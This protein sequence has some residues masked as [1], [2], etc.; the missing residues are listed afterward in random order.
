V[1]DGRSTIRELVDLVNQ[2]P[3]RSDGHSTVLSF[4]KL[5]AI[6][7]EVLAEQGMTPDSVPAAGQ[8]I[9]IRRNG[10]LST[11]GT[12]TDITD[13]V[14]PE[15]AAQAIDAARVIGLDIAG[16]DIVARDIS[17]PMDGQRGAVVEVNAGPGLRMHIEPTEGKPRPVGDAIV[18]LVYPVGE[19]GRIPLAGVTGTIGRTCAIKL[20]AQIL[21]ID[22]TPVGWTCET[23]IHLGDRALQHPAVRESDYARSLLL[24]PAVET[25]VCGASTSSIVREGLGYDRASVGIVTDLGPEEQLDLAGIGTVEKFVR[26]VRSVG[27]VVLASGVAVVNAEDPLTADMGEGC[28]GQVILFARDGSLPA[29]V[30]HREAG[31]RVAFLRDDSIVLAGEEEVTLGP[32]ASIVGRPL[33]ELPWPWEGVLSAVVAAWALGRSSDTIGQGLKNFSARNISC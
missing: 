31:G 21:A 22:G 17:Q 27:D 32:V 6:G 1:G 23:G 24:N 4:I 20:L 16:V 7:V 33:L 13:S 19:N 11:G 12:A 29:L 2:D 30:Q 8:L 25:A 28:K 5:D 9:L 15:V 26:A 18:E 3:R 14:H 10:N